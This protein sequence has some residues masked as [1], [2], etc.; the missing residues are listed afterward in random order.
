MLLSEQ[1]PLVCELDRRRSRERDRSPRPARTGA[2]RPSEAGVLSTDG[3]Q[4]E[5]R[6]LLCMRGVQN[7]C[8]RT[9]R[10]LP[11]RKVHAQQQDVA[12]VG[13]YSDTL[14][15]KT[16]MLNVQAM[17]LLSPRTHSFFLNELFFKNTCM[18]RMFSL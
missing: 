16:S 12:G 8:A 17:V 2:A 9:P 5:S 6:C 15:A 13:A 1:A 4:P 10:K 3:G 14:D 11:A 7:R 18:L